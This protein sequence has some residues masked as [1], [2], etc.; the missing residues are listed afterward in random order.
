MCY[1]IR[2]I[3]GNIVD[4]VIFGFYYILIGVIDIGDVCSGL[5]GFIERWGGRCRKIYY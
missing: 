1:W 4:R 3:I 2:Y 5:W